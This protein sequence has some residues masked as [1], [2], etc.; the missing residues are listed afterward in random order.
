MH[1]NEVTHI[2]H[3]RCLQYR[4]ACMQ[5]KRAQLRPN[6]I[7]ASCCC[8]SCFSVYRHGDQAICNQRCSKWLHA[9]FGLHIEV[10]VQPESGGWEE[11]MQVG[12]PPP[13][14]ADRQIGHMALIKSRIARCMWLH[15]HLQ[16]ICIWTQSSKPCATCVNATC[17]RPMPLQPILIRQ[18]VR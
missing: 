10:G 5:H 14:Q 8:I 2:C 1:C 9:C 7:I 11:G 3:L 16:Q 13:C 15:T 4:V 18:V 6:I 17:S 12:L